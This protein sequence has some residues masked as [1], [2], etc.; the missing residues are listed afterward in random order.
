MDRP[1][2]HPEGGIYS[3]MG[4]GRGLSS[5]H[6]KR[7]RVGRCDGKGRRDFLDETEFGKEP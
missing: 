5:G 6:A 1:A 7:R 2:F 3:P 4:P